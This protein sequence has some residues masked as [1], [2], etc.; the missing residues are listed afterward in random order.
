MGGGGGG[1]GLKGQISRNN[2]S[3]QASRQTDR[4]I[5]SEYNYYSCKN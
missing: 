5:D 2:Q 3:Q 4:Q 1:K